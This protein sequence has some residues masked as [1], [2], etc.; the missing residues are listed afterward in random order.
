MNYWVRPEH[1]KAMAMHAREMV[2]VLDVPHE[3]NAR[4]QAYGYQDVVLPDKTAIETGVVFTL[5]SHIGADILRELTAAGTL[6]IIM[7]LHYS[8]MGNHYQAVTYEPMRYQAYTEQWRELTD[9]RNSILVKYG[10]WALDAEPYDADKLAKA[11]TKELKTLRRAA[12][13]A[14]LTK[15]IREL[16]HVKKEFDSG[17][18]IVDDQKLTDSDTC[19]PTQREQ[20]QQGSRSGSQPEGGIAAIKQEDNRQGSIAPEPKTP[21]AH[22]PPTVGRANANIEKSCRGKFAEQVTTISPRVPQH[23]PMPD[24]R[25]NI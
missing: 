18:K 7:V 5:P 4:I 14:K 15:P 23:S 2:F 17:N 10:G 3:E 25:T 20:D 6:P 1:I 9:R 24:D 13:E 11:A 12:K 21:I 8:N 22:Y 19:E 16:P